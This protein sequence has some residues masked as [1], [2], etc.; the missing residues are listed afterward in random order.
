MRIGIGLD[1][2]PLVTGRKLVL[3]GVE[4]PYEKGLEGHSDADVLS[5][6][7]GDALLGSVGEGDLGR[8]FPDDDPAYEGISSQ[9]I[10][11][12][13]MVMVSGKGYRVVNVDTTVFAERPKLAPHVPRMRETL[14]STLSIPADALSVKATTMERMGFIG[15]EE[16]IAA[17]CVV[18]LA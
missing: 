14:A 1:C 9:Q 10:L 8:H 11:R 16:G 4:I 18:L 17:I 7:I 15:R 12:K 3:G 5:H 13:I 6:A 2:H